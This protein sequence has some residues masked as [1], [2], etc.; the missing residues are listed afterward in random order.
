MLCIYNMFEYIGRDLFFITFC[1]TILIH[2]VKT[3]KICIILKGNNHTSSIEHHEH[4]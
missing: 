3:L 1:I 2:F 4:S